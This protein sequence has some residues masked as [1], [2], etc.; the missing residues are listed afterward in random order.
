M[1]GGPNSQQGRNRRYVK[2][3]IGLERLAREEYVYGRIV[4][5]S[6]LFNADELKG[7]QE[8]IS[9]LRGDR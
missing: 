1:G 8:Y 9:R 3:Y 6:N 2:S 7:A 4:E 5:N